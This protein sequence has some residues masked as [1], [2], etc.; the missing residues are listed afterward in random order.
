[1][2]EENF[3]FLQH[4]AHSLLPRQFFD[5]HY[6]GGCAAPNYYPGN[7]YLGVMAN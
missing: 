5:A 3:S 1:M 7:K 2:C 4:D 6:F